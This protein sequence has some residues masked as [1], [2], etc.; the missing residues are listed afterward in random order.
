MNNETTI[1]VNGDIVVQ[2]ANMMIDIGSECKI[3][4]G[5]IDLH[6]AICCPSVSALIFITSSVISFLQEASTK[7]SP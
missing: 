5:H 6:K 7:T 1:E 3:I 4:I 2:D